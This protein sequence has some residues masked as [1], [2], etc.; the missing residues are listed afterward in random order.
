MLRDNPFYIFEI[1]MDASKERIMAAA[2]R[3]SLR[4]DSGNCDRMAEMLVKP[5]IRLEAELD[6]FPQEEEETNEGEGWF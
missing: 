2:E 4:S 6:W 3:Q 5:A 1:P